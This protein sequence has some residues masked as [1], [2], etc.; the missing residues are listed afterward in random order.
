MLGIAVELPDVLPV[1]GGDDEGHVVV[2]PGF[3]EGVEDEPDVHVHEGDPA[4]IAVHQLPVFVHVPDLHRLAGVV[5][6]GGVVVH[7]DLVDAVGGGL[8]PLFV[9]QFLRHPGVREK[10]VALEGIAEGGGG[11]VGGV[12]VPH[13]DMQEPVVLLPVPLDPVDGDRGDLIR[14]LPSSGPVVVDLVEAAVEPVGRMPLGEGGDRDGVKPRPPE[15]LEEI[16]PRKLRPEPAGLSFEDLIPRRA[17]VAH[18]AVV[19]AEKSGLQ[20]APGGQAGRVGAVVPVEPHAFPGDGVDV[21]GGIAEIPVAA[22]MIG[23]Q[24]VEVKEDDSQGVLLF[25][26]GMLWSHYTILY[27][28]FQ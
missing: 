10:V 13:V 23:A 24:G 4:V 22:E 17:S 18:R 16:G 15:L 26:F 9:D 25:V 6:Q 5:G 19:D 12:G 2:D 14:P 21:R 28:E 20:C 7:P 8:L 11:A 1:V 27:P 3:P